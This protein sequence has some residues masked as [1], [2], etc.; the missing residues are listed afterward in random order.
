MS[1][2]ANIKNERSFWTMMFHASGLYWDFG[3]FVTL[4]LLSGENV[5]LV[6][7]LRLF[8]GLISMAMFSMYTLLYP[9]I[10]ANKCQ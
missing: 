2:K 5:F 6:L 10:R 7:L 1:T 3:L 9:F 4:L 8:A